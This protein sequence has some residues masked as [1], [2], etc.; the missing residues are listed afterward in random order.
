MFILK[1]R[2]YAPGRW[3]WLSRGMATMEE[4]IEFNPDVPT[5]T[6][7]ELE[8]E[9]AGGELTAEDDE[10]AAPIDEVFTQPDILRTTFLWQVKMQKDEW[11]LQ[12]DQ[13]EGEVQDH[14]WA[15]L[16]HHWQLLLNTRL[17]EYKSKLQDAEALYLHRAATFGDDDQ[18][19]KNAFQKFESLKAG[20]GASSVI[21]INKATGKES[22]PDVY[23]KA[24]SRSKTKIS[25]HCGP[26][27]KA[28]TLNVMD[29]TLK[30]LV[31]EDAEDDQKSDVKQLRIISVTGM[32]RQIQEIRVHLDA[33]SLCAKQG[34]GGASK[35]ATTASEKPGNDGVSQDDKK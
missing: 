23:N 17:S 2:P 6:T 1:S 25:V 35:N 14:Q 19:T 34:G 8:K 18:K 10:W 20:E 3:A 31:Q 7:G 30:A 26:R 27:V 15:C 29:L 5:L 11:E 9:M 21:L 12:E 22:S 32:S 33:L 4:M 13:D 16:P 24:I 28:Y